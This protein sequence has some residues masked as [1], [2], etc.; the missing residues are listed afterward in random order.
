MLQHPATLR[1]A[2]VALRRIGS[3]LE[4]FLLQYAVARPASLVHG[5]GSTRHAEYFEPDK[6]TREAPF[7][8]D[9]WPTRW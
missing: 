1:P 3:L 2:S 6:F 9:D 5:I 8:P 7:F 4:A